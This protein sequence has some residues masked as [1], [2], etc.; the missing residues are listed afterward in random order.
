MEQLKLSHNKSN[1]M[2]AQRM[3]ENKAMQEQIL[4]QTEQFNKLVIRQMALDTEAKLISRI[5]SLLPAEDF[6]DDLSK[7]NLAEVLLYLSANSN[8]KPIEDQILS[9]TGYKLF[10][11]HLFMKLVKNDGN[12]VTHQEA[13]RT[14]N[15]LYRSNTLG[16]IPMN[17]EEKIIARLYDKLH[18]NK[19]S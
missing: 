5:G 10:R 2:E 3:I 4:L 11:L 1:Q 14:L 15:E 7:V 12:E 13:R 9:I 17:D 16:E 6:G 18:D 8:V 19:Y